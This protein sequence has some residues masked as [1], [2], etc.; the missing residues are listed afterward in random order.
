M[1]DSN[2]RLWYWF[3]IG[4]ISTYVAMALTVPIY[5][6]DPL[7][8][9]TI[10]CSLANYYLMEI[11]REWLGIP[12]PL[13][14]EPSRAIVTALQHAGFALGGGAATLVAAW[15]ILRLRQRTG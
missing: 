7:S 1:G 3:G 13:F 9:D 6:V 5:T 8:F 4:F 12:S 11:K 15:G 2:M 14:G 10:E